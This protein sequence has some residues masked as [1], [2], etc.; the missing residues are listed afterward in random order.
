MPGARWSGRHLGEL[1]AGVRAG[2][3]REAT[4]VCLPSFY[5]YGLLAGVKL[6]MLQATAHAVKCLAV[7]AVVLVGALPIYVA[8]MRLGMIVFARASRLDAHD[9]RTGTGLAA[10]RRGPGGRPLAVRGIYRSGGHPADVPQGSSRIL[11]APADPCLVRLLHDCHP[12]HDLLA[13]DAFDRL[14]AGSSG[15]RP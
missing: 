9:D 14:T 1:D 5:F 6:S 12:R 13:L 10:V 15:K 8:V 4:G 11:P 3:G 2:P 7:T